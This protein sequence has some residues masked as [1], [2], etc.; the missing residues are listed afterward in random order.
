MLVDTNKWSCTAMNLGLQCSHQFWH[1][2]D[3][4]LELT[5]NIHQQIPPTPK[6]IVVNK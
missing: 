3:W 6:M 4:K 2:H 1:W 5:L